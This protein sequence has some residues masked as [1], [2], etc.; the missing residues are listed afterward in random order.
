[1]HFDLWSFVVPRPRLVIFLMIE[2][3]TGRLNEY[4]HKLK[5][6]R[7]RRGAS[8]ISKFSVHSMSLEKSLS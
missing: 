3:D 4:N 6:S 2:G 7:G 8:A 5:W 1:M